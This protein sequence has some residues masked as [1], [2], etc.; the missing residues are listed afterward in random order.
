MWKNTALSSSIKYVLIL[1]ASI[2]H[3]SILGRCDQYQQPTLDCSTKAKPDTMDIS[4]TTE[5]ESPKV[6]KMAMFQ[7]L[8]D[9]IDSASGSRRAERKR[10]GSAQRAA[11]A[12][13]GIILFNSFRHAGLIGRVNR[14]P[15]VHFDHHR[16]AAAST[17]LYLGCS[18]LSSEYL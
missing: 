3:N 1:N 16:A 4:E 7:E 6:G 11:V 9:K 14:T 2:P 12:T 18:T 17:P 5:G 8:L 13:K 10:S 15:V